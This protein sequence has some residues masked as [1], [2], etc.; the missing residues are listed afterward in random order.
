MLKRYRSTVED[1]PSSADGASNGSSNGDGSKGKGR[2]A[3]VAEE[4]EEEDEGTDYAGREFEY[5]S[6]PHAH[7]VERA[8]LGVASR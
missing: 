2:A 1:V 3:S 7:S 5:F 6:L 8:Q 4:G